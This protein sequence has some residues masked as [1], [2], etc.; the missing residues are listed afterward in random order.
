MFWGPQLLSR[1]CRW[2]SGSL[3]HMTFTHSWGFHSR[4]CSSYSLMLEFS[5]LKWW[6]SKSPGSSDLWCSQLRFSFQL[7]S[8]NIVIPAPDF[9]VPTLSGKRS[10]QWKRSK[11]LWFSS[12][13]GWKQINTWPKKKK[14]EKK[15]RSQGSCKI[16][17]Y[18]SAEISAQSHPVHG[19]P[20]V[21]HS[22]FRK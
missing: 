8:H 6:R 12:K 3:Q 7:R 21:I 13:W 14:G 4:A 16:E 9:M 17:M 19:L 11:C 15:K 20:K 22:T 18:F 1:S 10:F 5:K 2:S